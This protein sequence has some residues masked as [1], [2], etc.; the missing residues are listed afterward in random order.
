[1]D[2]V[3]AIAGSPADNRN[4]VIEGLRICQRR[5]DM[6]LPTFNVL[7]SGRQGERLG[8]GRVKGARAYL[9]GNGLD[10]RSEVAVCAETGRPG[11]QHSVDL[12]KR[13]G[14]LQW[15]VELDTFS[16]G[17]KLDR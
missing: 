2:S 4:T 16:R 8:Q 7:P 13:P 6:R 14:R 5:S 10:R 12:F 1:M 9:L 17:Q 15:T 11:P 3:V